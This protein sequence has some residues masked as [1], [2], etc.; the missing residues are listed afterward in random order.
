MSD[1]PV[2]GDLEMRVLVH[3]FE[4]FR[5]SLERDDYVFADVM[6]LADDTQLSDDVVDDC[7]ASLRALDLVAVM[8]DGCIAPTVSGGLVA[9]SGGA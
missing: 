8:P 3:V 2:I 7:V 1:I 5:I 9:T 4:L 6:Q